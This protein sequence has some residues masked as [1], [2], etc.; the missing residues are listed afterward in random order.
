MKVVVIVK[1]GVVTG[2]MTDDAR[3]QVLVLDSDT[4]GCDEETQL[5][6]GGVD[7]ALDAMRQG[8]AQV[9]AAEVSS[10]FDDLKAELQDRAGNDVAEDVLLALF[11]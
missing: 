5:D 1:N 11:P 10:L 2:V 4:A 3:V 8:I 6:V 9:N 7:V